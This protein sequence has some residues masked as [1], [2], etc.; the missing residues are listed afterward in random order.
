MGNTD[1]R[2]KDLPASAVA[3]MKRWERAVADLELLDTWVDKVANQGHDITGFNVRAGGQGTDAALVMVKA[4]GP[5]GTPEILFVGAE[6]IV[7]AI[8]KAIRLTLSGE[9]RWKVDEF[10]TNGSGEA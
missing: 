1:M 4:L 3:Y 7:L 8:S 10:R 6:S 5:D 9:A 2:Y